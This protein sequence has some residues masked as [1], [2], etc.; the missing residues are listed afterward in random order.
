MATPTQIAKWKAE[1]QPYCVSRYDR[2]AMRSRPV[3]TKRYATPE[4]SLAVAMRRDPDHRFMLMVDY[5]SAV[6]A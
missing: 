2:D 6:P 3:G 5:A 4:E 1:P